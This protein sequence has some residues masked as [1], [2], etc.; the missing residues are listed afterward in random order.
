M[1]R[2]ALIILGCALGVSAAFSVAS[3]VFAAPKKNKINP[4]VLKQIE[5][6]VQDHKEGKPTATASDEVIIET[7]SRSAN[8][9][10]S[11]VIDT[12]PIA[13]EAKNGNVEVKPVA[14]EKHLFWSVLNDTFVYAQMPDGQL[15]LS[16]Y[17]TRTLWKLLGVGGAFG[18][19]AI[20][21]LSLLRKKTVNGALSQP[22]FKVRRIS[23]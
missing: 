7:T 14:Q 16:V 10:N 21:F 19:V 8:Q 11:E 18:I 6:T 17:P 5:Q 2:G 12:F 13:S 15:I 22:K 4:A 9:N 1:R 20:L 23:L 3:P